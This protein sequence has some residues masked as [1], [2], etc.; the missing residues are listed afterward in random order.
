M[1]F[2]FDPN[3]TG[4]I[5]GEFTNIAVVEPGGLGTSNL[6]LDPTKTF[7]V[8]VAWEITGPLAPLWIAALRTA[9]PDW[10]VAAYAESVGP[11]PELLLTEEPVSVASAFDQLPDAWRWKH[12]LTVPANLLEEEDP[13]P[14]GP[15]GVYRIV[16]TAFL[17]SVLGL[18]G[19]DIMGF[20]DGPVIKVENP[21]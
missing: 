14:G 16:V 10:S 4:F 12:R 21:D 18:A 17:N 6:V 5:S 2:Q 9:S 8:D 11:G 7:N 1:G 20:T 15:S 3:I 13:G 19:F